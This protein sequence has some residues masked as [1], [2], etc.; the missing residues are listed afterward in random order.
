MSKTIGVDEFA[1]S[2]EEIMK[3]V[4]VK[5]GTES[6]KAVKKSLQTG[7]RKVRSKANT[8]FRK[9]TSPVQGRYHLT[10][11][12]K[13]KPDKYG[14][15]TGEVGNKKY[16]GLVHLL[17]KGHRTTGAFRG[18]SGFVVGRPHM[19]PGADKAFAMFEKLMDEAVKKALQ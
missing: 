5:L 10:F 8:L 9:D 4:T 19:K 14:G 7:A 17:E 3:G 13:W 6:G 12:Y 2:I 15:A 16:P 1:L 11:S 18:G